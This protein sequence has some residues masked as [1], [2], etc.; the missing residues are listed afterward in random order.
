VLGAGRR[1]DRSAGRC[2]Y[3]PG[4]PQRH[5]HPL[6][7]LDDAP[8]VEGG[9]ELRRQL[10]GPL[11]ELG[12]PDGGGPVHVQRQGERPCTV[13]YPGWI[14]PAQG[15]HAR[16]VD[17][18]DA[19]ALASEA[20]TRTAR[21]L[22]VLRGLP[23]GAWSAPSRL[24]GWSR[25][26]V[27]CHLRYGAAALLRMTDDA[28]A[29][30]PTAYYPA[31]RAVERPGTL[32]PA[33]GEA[34]AGVLASWREAAA[35]LDRRWAAVSAEAWSCPV[36]EPPDN[37]DLGTVPLH[38]LALARLTEVEVHGTDLDVGLE[39]WSDV[40]VRV[41]LPTRLAWLETRRT[42]HRE[43]DAG[44]QG[45]WLLV[46]TDGVIPPWRLAVEGSTVTSRP[47]D[48]AAGDATVEG[49][50]RDLLALLLGR[51]PVAPL[52]WSGDADLATAFGRAFPGP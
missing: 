26:I 22:E 46:A 47:A 10:G 51:P 12:V 38:R 41:G 1:S 49:T 20:A 42:N 37:P 36:V 28:L 31:G 11:V 2:R 52:R 9:V 25:L 8:V 32:Q 34:V 23:E 45:S 33:P 43:V 29:G 13:P 18:A 35:A 30:R 17:A 44:V 19:R 3:A 6:G 40:L 48:G 27:A 21:L 4:W 39:G 16:G 5:Q 7:P 50:G 14:A 24:P 15:I